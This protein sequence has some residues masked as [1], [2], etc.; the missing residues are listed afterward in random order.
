[1]LKSAIL[2]KQND[3]IYTIE[4][5]CGFCISDFE[6]LATPLFC[7]PERGRDI[8]LYCYEKNIIGL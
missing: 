8:K 7:F 1:M 2:Y 6:L 4:Y 5:K 3:F